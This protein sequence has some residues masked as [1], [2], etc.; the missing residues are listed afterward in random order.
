MALKGKRVINFDAGQENLYQIMSGY[1][2]WS[3]TGGVSGGGIVGT[4]YESGIFVLLPFPA[5]VTFVS[6]MAQVSN[7]WLSADLYDVNGNWVDQVMNCSVFTWPPLQWVPCSANVSVPNTNI[8][9]V[10]FFAGAG[11]N[12]GALDN[13][14]VDFEF[15]PSGLSAPSNH[16][17]PN[18]DCGAVAGEN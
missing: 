11:Y 18:C 1:G 8:A 12:Y 10:K 7:G 6:A 5:K 9:K 4:P 17:V 3:P 16:G 14:R 15:T 2:Q 13:V